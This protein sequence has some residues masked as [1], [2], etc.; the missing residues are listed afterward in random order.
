MSR[1]VSCYVVSKL[2]CL[3]SSFCHW[4]IC[5]EELARPRHRFGENGEAKGSSRPR[6]VISL[7]RTDVFPHV[8]PCSC[9]DCDEWPEGL[10]V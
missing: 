3:I 10:D 2:Q 9:V 8:F 1:V 4:W 5:G 6:V 7:K